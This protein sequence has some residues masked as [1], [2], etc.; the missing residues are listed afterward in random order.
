MQAKLRASA[1]F[2][3]DVR[4]EQSGKMILVGA[5]GFGLCLGAGFP[6]APFTLK[7]LVRVVGP[8]TTVADAPTV[9]VLLN[10]EV[11]SDIQ[12]PPEYLQIFAQ[13]RTDLDVRF[14]ALIRECGELENVDTALFIVP[15][16]VPMLEKDSVVG[17]R[18]NLGQGFAS[19]GAL[20]VYA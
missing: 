5:Y 20:I 6:S 3:D 10:G 2:A 11:I 13:F 14:G 8:P 16:D 4:Y 7:A 12:P 9:Q 19:A 17:L 1:V 18:I 15:F